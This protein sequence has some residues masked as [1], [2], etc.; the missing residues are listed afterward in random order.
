MGFSIKSITKA[1][2]HTTKT[3]SN[4]V[5]MTKTVVD[6]HELKKPT[7]DNLFK[8][9]DPVLDDLSPSHQMVQVATTGQTT[10]EGQSPYFQKIAPMIVNAF[11][12]GAGSAAAAVSD[13]VEGNRKGAII[14]A[15]GA[16][17]GYYGSSAAGTK[18]MGVDG[19]VLGSIVATG[20]NAYRVVDAFGNTQVEYS[21]EPKVNVT[22]KYAP[23]SAPLVGGN[24]GY[25]PTVA[26]ADQNAA[27]NAA[28]NQLHADNRQ[29]GLLILAVIAG[30]Y[31]F[32]KGKK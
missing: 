13:G 2:V 4:P 16:A 27:Q 32:S 7:L 26:A 24:I 15:A 8:K 12:P 5:K 3:L 9:I 23:A 19:K 29:K 31:L 10:T 22:P 11:L 20:I 6:L 18:I 14:N 30:V 28:I 1:I 25:I 17:V 21:K